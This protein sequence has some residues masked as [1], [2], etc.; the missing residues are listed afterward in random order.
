MF[1][2]YNLGNLTQNKH[3]A[4]DLTWVNVRLL[5]VWSLAAHNKWP[6]A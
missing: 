4:N 2:D 3:Q 6:P 1:F 5:Q